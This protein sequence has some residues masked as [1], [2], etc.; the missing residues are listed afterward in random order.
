MYNRYTGEPL[1]GGGMILDQYNLK[2]E[3]APDTVIKIYIN[4]YEKGIV[5]IPVGLKFENIP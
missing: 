4:P 2:P 1:N 5:L 3:N